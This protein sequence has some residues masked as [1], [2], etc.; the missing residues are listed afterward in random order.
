MCGSGARSCCC[1]V[2]RLSETGSAAPGG[3]SRRRAGSVDLHSS[4]WRRQHT[5]K[6]TDLISRLGAEPT[7]LVVFLAKRNRRK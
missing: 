1:L 6:V 2:S 4:I 3:S 7:L 5:L